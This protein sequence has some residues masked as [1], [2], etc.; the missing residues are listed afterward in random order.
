[1]SEHIA[2]Y[3]KILTDADWQAN[4]GKIAKIAGE[5]GIGALMK[6]CEAAHKKVEWF[7]KYQA[8]NRIDWRS[9][10]PAKS[11]DE[12]VDET[13]KELTKLY[14]ADAAPVRKLFVE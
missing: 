13:E 1:M 6:K 4:K 2:D 14:M 5:T 7:N 8:A 12:V 3:P 9:I 10:D 11:K